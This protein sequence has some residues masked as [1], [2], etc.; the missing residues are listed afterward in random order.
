MPKESWHSAGSARAY[1]TIHDNSPV[2]WNVELE[3]NVSFRNRKSKVPLSFRFACLIEPCAQSAA[4]LQRYFFESESHPEIWMRVYDL[5]DS[6]K[7]FRFRKDF[8]CEFTTDRQRIR[9]INVA[10][11]LSS[12][13]RAPSLP[14]ESRV[15]DFRNGDKR[16]AWAA[17]NLLTYDNRPKTRK[18]SLIPCWLAHSAGSRCT[19]LMSRCTLL[20]RSTNFNP[21]RVNLESESDYMPQSLEPTQLASAVRYRLASGANVSQPRWRKSRS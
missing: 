16:K 18:L 21:C 2:T 5:R 8:N 4:A 15:N 1:A 12:D 10:T 17:T 7:A 9:H 3:H 19:L 13:T 11:R 6:I 14:P 20:Y